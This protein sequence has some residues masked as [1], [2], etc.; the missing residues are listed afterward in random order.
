MYELTYRLIESSFEDLSGTDKKVLKSLKDLL[1]DKI[2]ISTFQRDVGFIKEVPS[3]KQRIIE[4][5]SQAQKLV[6]ENKHTEAIAKWQEV[7]RLDSENRKAIVGIEEAERILKELE[8]KKREVTVEQVKK[9][10]PHC[11]HPNTRELKYC[12]QCGTKLF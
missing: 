4:L 9:Y 8:E 10:C 11:G 3:G 12:P 7:L 6:E 2:S 5:S 1:S